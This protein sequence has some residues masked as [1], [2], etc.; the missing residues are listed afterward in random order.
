MSGP[1]FGNTQS[2]HSPTADAASRILGTLGSDGTPTMNT[3]K[4][5]GSTCLVGQLLVAMDNGHT[6][7]F[8]NG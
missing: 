6:I 2:G 7:A 4:G 3:I 5:V 8:G 1:S